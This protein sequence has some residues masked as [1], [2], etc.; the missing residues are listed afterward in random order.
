MQADAWCRKSHQLSEPD[1]AVS[2]HNQKMLKRLWS[3]YGQTRSCLL[4]VL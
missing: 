1:A 2:G 4:C 3:Y